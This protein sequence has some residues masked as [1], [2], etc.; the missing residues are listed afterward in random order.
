M[1]SVEEP[2]E[3]VDREL[4]AAADRRLQISTAPQLKMP[5]QCLRLIR[6]LPATQKEAS[7]VPDTPAISDTTLPREPDPVP[8]AGA[9]S[10]DVADEE[11]GR[12]PLGF[13]DKA[14]GRLPSTR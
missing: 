13:Y 10:Q 12:K 7:L 9:G 2:R 6:P 14:R 5:V 11:G 8:A 1:L 3:E 4:S